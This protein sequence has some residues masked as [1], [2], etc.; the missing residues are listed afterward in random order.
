MPLRLSTKQLADALHAIGPGVATLTPLAR[1]DAGG[2]ADHVAH[3]PRQIKL[4][5]LLAGGPVQLPVKPSG[6]AA[7]AGAGVHGGRAVLRQ[8][9][10]STGEQ[11]QRIRRLR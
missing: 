8:V 5:G 4:R 3:Q 2:V 1:V 10:G 7:W 9:S 11:T 6:T